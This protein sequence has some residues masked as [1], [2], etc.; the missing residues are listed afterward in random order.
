ME[1]TT[2]LTAIAATAAVVSAIRVL[3]ADLRQLHGRRRQVATWRREWTVYGN[4]TTIW[5]A[6]KKAEG[7][8]AHRSVRCAKHRGLAPHVQGHLVAKVHD[9]LLRDHTVVPAPVGT[10]TWSYVIRQGT[11]I[12]RRCWLRECRRL[13]SARH[14]VEPEVAPCPYC[15]NLD[16]RT[17]ELFDAISEG[18]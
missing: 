6:T 5:A 14:F 15:A 1:A 2:G 16:P 3:I 9:T 11:S 18:V 17:A 12:D 10:R 13:S 7:G 4:R 8:R